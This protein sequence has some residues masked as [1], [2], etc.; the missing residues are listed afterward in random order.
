MARKSIARKNYLYFAALVLGSLYIVACQRLPR[1][2]QEVSNPASPLLSLV[3]T[4][5]DF[6]GKWAWTDSRTLQRE[7]TPTAENKEQIEEA[8]Y[9]LW[10]SF[11]D[12]SNAIVIGHILTKYVDSPQIPEKLDPKTDLN[13]PRG[14]SFVPQ[15]ASVGTDEV[16]QCVLDPG[17]SEQDHTAA[18]RIIVGYENLVSTLSFSAI[19]QMDRETVELIL[20]EVL[21]KIDKRIQDH[22]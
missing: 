22:K 6:S 2:V 10:G 19:G 9:G 16:A 20:N 3:M 8:S 5:A 15:L 17:I 18:C 13:M 11:R 12:E 1:D 14:E 7:I 21:V 4:K